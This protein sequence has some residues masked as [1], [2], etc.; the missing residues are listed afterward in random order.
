M[1]RTNV[2][3][4]AFGIALTTAI[5]FVY[6]FFDQ[7]SDTSQSI[8]KLEENDYKVLT[9]GEYESLLTTID[10]LEKEKKEASDQEKNDKNQ[11]NANKEQNSETQENKEVKTVTITITEGMVLETIASELSNLGVIDDRTSFINYFLENDLDRGIQLG[12][13]EIKS[14]ISYQEIADLITR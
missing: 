1:N 9:I 3:A 2:Q 8:K 7:T 4:F 10:S 12:S 13:Y 11:E 5:F 14:G 6:S